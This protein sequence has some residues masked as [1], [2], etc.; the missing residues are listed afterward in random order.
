MLNNSF[1]VN[2]IDFSAE[3]V[4]ENE[5]T[6]TDIQVFMDTIDSVILFLDGTFDGDLEILAKNL[7]FYRNYK[8]IDGI[9][10]YIR[11]SKVIRKL[12]LEITRYFINN[13]DEKSKHI[14]DV[15]RY[16]YILMLYDIACYYF[17]SHECDNIDRAQLVASLLCVLEKPDKYDTNILLY[18]LRISGRLFVVFPIHDNGVFSLSPIVIRDTLTY[19]AH[20]ASTDSDK[21]NDINDTLNA[22]FHDF[23]DKV[24]SDKF[25]IQK[26]KYTEI[27]EN[28]EYIIEQITGT[29]LLLHVTRQEDPILKNSDTFFQLFSSYVHS[30]YFQYNNF[31]EYYSKSPMVRIILEIYLDNMKNEIY[32]S[33]V[34]KLF[35]QLIEHGYIDDI[36]LKVFGK[37]TDIVVSN[38]YK[39]PITYTQAMSFIRCFVQRVP[40]QFIFQSKFEK[41][42]YVGRFTKLLLELMPN[43]LKNQEKNLHYRKEFFSLIYYYI[44]RVPPSITLSLIDYPFITVIMSMFDLEHGEVRSKAL[45]IINELIHITLKENSSIMI[46]LLRKFDDFIPILET[47]INDDDEQNSY[48]SKEILSRLEH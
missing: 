8:D 6:Q 21:M 48:I 9:N 2:K 17:F 15:L 46:D 11:E 41:S 12:F 7:C 33:E 22:Y 19:M 1:N 14:F 36:L 16:F 3:K 30:R 4:N 44:M 13:K 35:I 20:I 31:L 37:A 45:E 29:T 38:F 10:C 24:L 42:E 34:F 47:I 23:F 43:Y 25:Q 27:S 5:V 26:E 40:D 39:Y 18:T 28:L 32:I